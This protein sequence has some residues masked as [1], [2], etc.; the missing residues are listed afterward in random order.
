MEGE[1][2][3]SDPADAAG[4]VRDV[5]KPLCSSGSVSSTFCRL[6]RLNETP[7][8]S[9]KDAGVSFEML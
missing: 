4:F 5:R 8:M 9:N 1:Q 7:M 6:G 3:S 2:E